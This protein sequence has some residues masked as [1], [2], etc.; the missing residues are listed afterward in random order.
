MRCEKCN[1]E[2]NYFQENQTCGWTCPQCGNSIATTYI[3]DLQLDET[4]YT[5]TL[6]PTDSASAS[7]LKVLS[8]LSGLTVL[9]AKQLTINGG[10]IAT[11]K[12]SLIKEYRDNLELTGLKYIISPDFKY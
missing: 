1:N 11:D 8:K 10:I 9:K 3:S 2:M 4:L 6:E 12:A 7:D 5:L